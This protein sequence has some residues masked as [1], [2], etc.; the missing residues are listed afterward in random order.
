[1]QK[2]EVIHLTERCLCVCVCVC[3]CVWCILISEAM[4]QPR[5]H[6]IR[7][8]HTE[9]HTHTHTHTLRQR[10][11]NV[12]C[13]HSCFSFIYPLLTERVKRWL[14]RMRERERMRHLRT[15]LNTGSYF[16][17]S[18][19]WRSACLHLNT[20]KVS[21]IILSLDNLDTAEIICHHHQH[22]YLNH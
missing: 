6:Q 11:I 22:C 1:M 2:W 13:Y 5:K 8:D 15:C 7:S 3:V 18:G 20:G 16:R 9:T 14:E 21:D 19:R 12:A 4:T 17:R 10:E